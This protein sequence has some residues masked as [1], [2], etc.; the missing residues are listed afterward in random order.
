MAENNDDSFWLM[1]D[2]CIADEVID[3]GSKRKGLRACGSSDALGVYENEPQ[4]GGEVYYTGYC[5]S[6]NQVFNKQEFHASSH[7]SQFGIEGGA[8]VERK[9]FER[10]PKASPMNKQ[11]VKTFIQEIDPNYEGL[12]YRGIKDE[13]NRF[14]GH[15]TKKDSKGNVIARYYPETSEDS[16][17]WP[18]GYK[19]RNHPKDFKYGKV[20]VTGQS[21]KLSGQVKYEHMDFRD[22]IIVGGEEDKASWCQ[23]WTESA[24]KKNNGD[25]IGMPV[26]SGTTGE[27]SLVNQIK[28]NYDFIVRA[29]NIYLALD[30]DDAGISAMEDICKIL[31]KEKI[32][33]VRWS[34]KDPNS[35]IHNND[36]A[37]DRTG[38]PTTKDWSR[39]AISDFWLAKEYVNS[40]IFASSDLM[41]HIKEALK[42]PRIPL[43]NYMSVLQSMT[44]GTGIIKN[45]IYNIIGITSCGKSTHVNSMVYSFA[46]LPEEKTAVISLEMTKGEYGVDILSLHLETNLYWKEADEVQEYLDSPEVLEEANRLF[47]DEHGESR[48]YVVDDRKGT[49][50]SLEELCEKL[51][52]KYGVTVIVIDVLTDLLRVTSNEEQASHMNWQSNFVKEGVTIFNVLHTRKL[53]PSSDGVARKCTEYDALGSS[54]FVQKAAGN[55]VINRNKEAPKDDWIE[56]NSTYLDVPKL[57]QGDTGEGGVWLYDPETRQSYD[58]EKFFID[59]PDRLPVGY[60]L[61]ISSF[62]RAYYEEGGRGYKGEGSLGSKKGFSK[63]SGNPSKK[64]APIDSFNLEDLSGVSV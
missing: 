34:K 62:D 44:R 26:V 39:Q 40:G 41:I 28:N 57:R 17:A 33:I 6:C 8:V 64:D 24:K 29:E 2:Y 46:F 45:R 13:Y 38:K 22:I 47:V 5:R 61:S 30:N 50:A 27:G 19:C 42:M 49:V 60:D 12:G 7:A 18:T 54:I 15:L 48:F 37:L 32:K 20:G 21:S 11:E 52:C 10:K 36:G 23:I 9:K 53:Q 51:R 43:P 1:N 16:G 3:S 58:R 31:P 14:F 35:Y 55:F 4:D 56:K 59:N 25:Y 63:R